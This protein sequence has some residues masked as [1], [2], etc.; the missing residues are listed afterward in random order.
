LQRGFKECSLIDELRR[1]KIIEIHFYKENFFLNKNSSPTDILRWDM[2]VLFAKSY[3]LSLS[4]S[5]KRGNKYSLEKGFYP[6]KPPIGYERIL[7][8][9][10]TPIVLDKTRA[11]YI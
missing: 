1:N 3:V 4:E 9:N 2:A 10:Q 8:N 7:I 5:V 6:S 11:Y